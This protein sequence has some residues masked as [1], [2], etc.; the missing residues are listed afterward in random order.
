MIPHPQGQ[1]NVQT[2]EA[3]RG[4]EL[5]S[6]SRSTIDQALLTDNEADL[7][8]GILVA[9]GHHGPH[10]VIDNGNHIQLHCLHTKGCC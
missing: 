8:T 4:G 6:G 1:R 10:R 9:T 3:T 5:A 7:A 2:E